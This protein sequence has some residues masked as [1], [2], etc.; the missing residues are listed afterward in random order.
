MPWKNLSTKPVEVVIEDAIMILELEQL[1]EW[2]MG[3]DYAEFA[4]ARIR[5]EF[6]DLMKKLKAKKDPD[7][8]KGSSFLEKI[9]DNLTLRINKIDFRVDVVRL[10]A[11]KLPY[12]LPAVTT[13]TPAG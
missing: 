11:L 5:S 4:L 9:Y 6:K 13:V 12:P 8:N 3:S 7:N 2:I 10:P 1:G